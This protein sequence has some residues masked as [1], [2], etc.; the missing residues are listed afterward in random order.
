MKRKY[1]FFGGLIA[2]LGIWES[3]GYLATTER[4]LPIFQAFFPEQDLAL[5]IPD[6][7]LRWG[8]LVVFSEQHDYFLYFVLRKCAHL[9]L[10][11]CLTLYVWYFIHRYTRIESKKI[12][13]SLLTCIVLVTAVLDEVYQS[14]IPQRVS[15]PMDLLLDFS[16]IVLSLTALWVVRGCKLW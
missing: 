9:L 3:F 8:G 16:G 10:F 13:T 12:K 4:M 1:W 7:S 6:S 14:F 5:L 2:L 11:G 15:S